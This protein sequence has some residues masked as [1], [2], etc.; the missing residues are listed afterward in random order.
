MS[1]ILL[2]LAL[3]AAAPPFDWTL[4]GELHSEGWRPMSMEPG[5]A[6]SIVV[7]ELG[8]EG[9]DGP[10][11]CLVP[12]E[13]GCTAR[14]SGVTPFP[15]LPGA[16]PEYS[17]VSLP[18]EHPSD[19]MLLTGVSRL[20]PEGDTLWTVLLDTAFCYG[21]VGSIVMPS[22]NGGCL[23]AWEPPPGSDRWKVYRLDASGN[24]IMAAGFRLQGGP[25]IG[26]GDMAE[27]PDGGVLLTG[28]TDSLGMSL[29]MF[30]VGFDAG[31]D[32]YCEY[33]DGLRFHARGRLLAIDRDGC[34][35]VAGDTGY[36]RE[37]GFFMPPAYTDVFLMKFDQEGEFLWSTVYPMPL[38]NTP[39]LMEID[40]G[41]TVHIL[42]RSME[43]DGS[44]PEGPDYSLLTYGR[45]NGPGGRSPSRGS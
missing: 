26:L 45:I 20:G 17:G 32:R 28:V 5:T 24:V 21:S 13:M 41:G 7:I 27:T 10:L 2:L 16:D 44:S 43:D 36:E 4:V 42:V 6:L 29:Y 34:V 25:V 39:V 11:R 33:I 12:V 38:E 35:Y 8:N 18:E 9:V 1:F 40:E 23:A 37:D 31:G 15:V 14:P 19:C 30:L 3:D 22:I